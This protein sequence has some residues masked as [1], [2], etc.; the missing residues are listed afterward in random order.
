MRIHCYLV[1]K[2]VVALMNRIIKKLKSTFISIK[3]KLIVAV[4]IVQAFSSQIGQG[5]N[6]AI[7]KSRTVLE[8]RGIHTP[9]LDGSMGI[10]ITSAIS[11]ILS[12]LI[13][14]L[15]YDRLVLKRLKKVLVFTEKLGNNDL[16]G[17]LI[18]KGNDEISRLGIALNRSTSNIRSL[19]SEIVDI[20]K[21]INNS[22][23]DLLT[24]T[25][26]S[27]SSINA[28]SSTSST[29][30]EEAA[31]LLTATKN[32]NLAIEKIFGTTVFLSEKINET[33]TSSNEMKTRAIEMKEKVSYSLENANKTYS[34]RQS[35]IIRAIEEGKIVEEIKLMSDTIKGISEQ[36]NL[37]ALNAS[38]EAA[39]AGEQGKGF[40]VV[41]EEVRNLAEQ[42]KM[43]IS[44]IEILVL[45][46]RGVFDNLSS[47]S[48]DILEYI[49]NNVKADYQLLLETGEQYENDA[50]LINNISSEVTASAQTMNQFIKEIRKVIDNV[51][52]MTGKTS[53]ST[54]E[55]YGSLSDINCVMDTVNNSMVNQVTF[56]NRLNN[57]IE[58]FKI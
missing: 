13:I 11:V 3:F 30:N 45:Q 53:D 52:E 25:Q 55:I 42:S 38:I 16:S 26:S 12:V 6:F 49:D 40:M 36:T 20:S 29:L 9:F 27:S 54:G 46:V 41:A 8:N 1:K 24:S 31:T 56:T 57:S 14:V 50:K 35:K 51:V 32:A 7:T 23:N 10:R 47:S 4:V 21:T 2:G 44:N 28:I 17:N 34:E 22:S 18:F 15:I 43:A 33:L 39:R 58:K 5:I 37:L 19:V 48:Q